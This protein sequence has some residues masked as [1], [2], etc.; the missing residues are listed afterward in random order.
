MPKAL[1]LSPRGK[2]Y[3]GE[4]DESL[5][6]LAEV[7]AARIEAAFEESASRGLL[8]LATVELE[9]VLPA[10][11]AFWRDF[12]RAYLTRLCHT[13]GLAGD[14]EVSAILADKADLEATVDAA[15]PMTG[16]EYL[17]TSVLN[18]LWTDLDLM[19]RQEMK[20][21]AGGPQAY[22]K[23]RNPIW[24]LV[25]R[26]SFH[27]AENKR[28]EANPFAFLATYTSRVSKQARL[29]YLPLGKA[30]EEYAGAK[31]RNALLALLT[32]VQRAAEKSA[33]VRE[34][35]DS[36][37][38]FHPMAWTPREAHRFLQDIP[39][40]ESSGILVR[41]PDW[42]KGGRPSRPEVRVTI[43]DKKAQKLGLDALL[44]FSVSLTLDGEPITEDEWRSILSSTQG[45]V[46]LKGKWVEVDKEKLSEVLE[47]WK[48]LEEEDFR[49][50]VSF[51]QGMRLL[52]NAGVEKSEAVLTQDQTR[53]WSGITAG[54][55][56]ENIL[57]DLRDPERIQDCEAGKDLK[58]VLRPYQKIGANW[59]WFMYRLGLG[60]CLAD[61]MGL[62]KTIQVLSLLLLIKRERQK[63]P[64]ASVPSLIVVPASLIANWKAEIAAFAPSLSV[65]FAHPS[66]NPASVLDGLAQDPRGRFSGVDLV[67]TTYGLL[68]R[69]P[70]LR[71]VEWNL[72]V[73]DEAQAIKNPSTRQTRAAKNLKAR[74]RIVLTGTPV[75]NRLSD[76]W[77][78]FD[79]IC[80]GLLGSAKA[81][82]QFAKSLAARKHNQYGPLRALIRPY[83]L[84]RL[85]TDNRIIAD[86]P[87]KTE[88]R[89]FC[90]LT[91][92]QAALYQQSVEELAER[93]GN[94]DGI[95]RRGVILAFI[96]RFKQ[97]CNH[98][99]QWLGT[100]EYA[101]GESGK[102]QRLRDLCEEVAARQEK[103]LVFTQFREVTSPLSDFL[104]EVFKRPGLTLHGG[105][106]V[107]VRR[108]L[109]EEFQK[110][111]GPPFFIL[112]LKAGGTGLNLTAATHVIHFDRWWNPAVE[113]Q[114]TDRAYRIGQKR[115]VL[116]HKFVCR[117]TIEDKIDSLIEEKK[118]LAHDLLED[119]GEKMLTE[120][121]NEELLKFVSLDIRSALED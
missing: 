90:S 82:G 33:M 79:F 112:S 5:P 96:L 37:E 105:T 74:V 107:K 92:R 100:G 95:R 117:G 73:L 6:A 45:L 17:D 51:I 46:L 29:Q 58:A 66:E 24:N 99:A 113:N 56:L 121:S 43:G 71:E 9:T 44:D 50:G 23:A 49:G 115:N 25:G 64:R 80:P 15:P 22:L 78:L 26:V 18:I 60:T 61:D 27:L 116:V 114:A 65:I 72:A 104:E 120:M 110:D 13:P 7:A 12:G 94:V 54:E 19:V 32:P 106:A 4:C 59:L 87:E 53:E 76:L 89:A 75:E 68:L 2:L 57:D 103:A 14:Q 98:P 101:A 93:L 31:N 97:I 3:F 109:I 10:T 48:K 20:G 83:I 77:S 70:W 40:F 38:V 41:V 21:F 108:A 1:A 91:K 63:D 42:W 119:G 111:G 8:H 36:G 84:R 118:G 47:Q 62:G 16:I 67:I 88:V 55:W 52:A 39:V 85:K 34:L 11:F 81:F 35:V 30:L 69:A 28:D 86:L 102:F